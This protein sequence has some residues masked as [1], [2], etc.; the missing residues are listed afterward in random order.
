MLHSCPITGC[1][2]RVTMEKLMC[3]YHWQFVPAKLARAV[4][5][6]YNHGECMPEHAARC[7]EATAIVQRK[8]DALRN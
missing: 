6:A 2:S 3:F 1:F 8:M 5:A 7:A 4:Y